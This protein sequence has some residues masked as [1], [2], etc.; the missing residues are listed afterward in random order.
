MYNKW[1][2]QWFSTM[3]L[4]IDYD[5]KK[6]QKQFISLLNRLNCLVVFN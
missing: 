3:Y 5:A 6:Q 4:G 2:N 1:Y